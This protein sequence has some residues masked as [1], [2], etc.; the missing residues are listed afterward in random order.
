MSQLRAAGQD[1]FERPYGLVR[2]V[3]GMALHARHWIHRYGWTPELLGRVA[4]TEREH[5]RRNPAALMQK[6]LTMEEYLA[7]RMIADP[8]RL[9]DCC[10][11]TDGALALVLASAE[12]A[13]DLAARP[14]FVTGFALG[15]GPEMNAMTFYQGELGRTPARH[16]ARELWRNT[17][18]SPGDID[19]VQL[20][21]AFTP[22]IPIQ[23]EEYG[24]CGEGE[25]QALLLEGRNPPYN[26]SGGG[27]S[28]AY[29]HGVNLILEGVRQVRGTSTSQVPGVRHCL[30]TSGNVVPTGAI[31]LS[32]EP[33]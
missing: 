16:V 11:E 20:Y 6:P 26:T 23:L 9:Y 13:A 28:E 15:S 32:R 22:Q 27:L 18:L 3:D 14:A 7:S 5:A 12:R 4:I 24:F 17:G 1:Q 8:L 30:V 21:D 19:V 31:V 29:V 10:L 2:P 25:A 33:W